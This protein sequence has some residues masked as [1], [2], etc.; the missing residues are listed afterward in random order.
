MKPKPNKNIFLIWLLPFWLLVFINPF[1]LFGQE[2]SDSLNI[3]EIVDDSLKNYIYKFDSLKLYL[4]K[5][6]N[7]QGVTNRVN[8]TIDSAISDNVAKIGKLNKVPDSINNY[9]NLNRILPKMP[10]LGS[11]INFTDVLNP[12]NEQ[13]IDVLKI[14]GLNK[15]ENNISPN[16]IEEFS[17]LKSDIIPNLPSKL[18]IDSLSLKSIEN[19][20]EELAKNNI[21]EL[22]ELD[23]ME[24]A[25][26]NARA[27]VEDLQWDKSKIKSSKDVAKVLSD[28]VE[29]VQKGM[30]KM[31]DFKGKYS[32]VNLMNPNGPV[33]KEMDKTPVE[34]WNFGLGLKSKW[35]NG[36]MLETAPILAY[37]L[38]N[39]LNIGL[40]GSADLL[41]Y[42][43][44]SLAAKFNKQ[45]SYR[46]FSQYK[47]YK[48]IFAHFEFEQPYT[49]KSPEIRENWYDVKRNKQKGW[50]GLGIEYK[51]YKKLK[52]QTQ[53]LYN[54]VPPDYNSNKLD[55]RW[56]MRI[57]LNI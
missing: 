42:H 28:N 54:I 44:D 1:C 37:N 30:D 56:G 51:I 6:I 48:N 38:T 9:S 29:A 47:F 3:N 36:L 40:S 21:E 52:G 11:N 16:K 55:N 19:K 13:Q 32:K 46:L 15:I 5:N 7:R 8:E 2:Q 27:Q 41:I 53:L 49:P 10:D 12:T 34:Q 39:K 14:L 31:K 26:N 43:K 45:I 35:F 23:K 22:Q 25:A 18:E 20:A 50:L 4:N 17:K 33:L 24:G 57:N